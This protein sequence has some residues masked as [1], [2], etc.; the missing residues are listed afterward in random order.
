VL[1]P[2]CNLRMRNGIAPL[3]RYLEQGVRVAIGTDNCALNDNED[4]LG[5][6]RL[7]GQLAREPA[8][9]G[10]PPPDGRQLIEMLTG[11]GARAAGAG[12]SPG[13][14]REGAAADLV[15]VS[16]DSAR[17]PYLD[18]GMPLLQAM[19][20]KSSGSDVRLTMVNG[21]IVYR[22]GKHL[23]ADRAEA[24][25]AAARSAQSAL[26]SAGEPGAERGREFVRALSAH[27]TSH[28][29]KTGRGGP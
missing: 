11:N 5:E 27:Y 6:L 19:L 10:R 8:W 26:R 24:R 28:A 23:K 4:L 29:R 7:A 18:P 16:L 14:L 9:G 3:A 15:A 12:D 22:D 13:R 17:E 1:N 20:S 2:G 25:A 21:A